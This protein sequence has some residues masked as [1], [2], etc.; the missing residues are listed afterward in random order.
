[1]RD[2]SVVKSRFS[3]QHQ[4]GGS[5]LTGTPGESTALFW[6]YQVLHSCGAHIYRQTI[7][8]YINKFCLKK[9]RCHRHDSWWIMPSWV[10]ET[11]ISIGFNLRAN[12][13][14]V[15]SFGTSFYYLYKPTDNSRSCKHHS[16]ISQRIQVLDMLVSAMTKAM[17]SLEVECSPARENHPFMRPSV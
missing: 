16:W 17:E 9:K 4:L 1:M 3:F 2:A 11:S 6:P 5:Q 10:M 7:L 14:S 8:T 13:S 15:K 12:H